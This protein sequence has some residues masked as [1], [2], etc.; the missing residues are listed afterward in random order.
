M[1]L[2]IY[3][4]IYIL[5]PMVRRP[6]MTSAGDWALKLIKANYLSTPLVLS[7]YTYYNAPPVVLLR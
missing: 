1:V 2:S 5:S 7:L 4:S 6:D 3:L